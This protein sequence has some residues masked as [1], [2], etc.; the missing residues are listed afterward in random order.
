MELNE[1]K[2]AV[3]T[4]LVTIHYFTEE[5]A[6]TAAEESQESDAYMWSNVEDPKVIADYLALDENDE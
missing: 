6:R 5:E 2:E 4:S 1:L 3:V